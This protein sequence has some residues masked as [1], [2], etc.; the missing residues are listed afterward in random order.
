M[1]PSIPDDSRTETLEF[2]L[3]IADD[4]YFTGHRLGMWLAVSPTLEEDNALTSIAQ[5]ELGHARLWY[6]VV[7]DERSTTTDDLAIGR[8]HDDRRNSILVEREHHD[9][10][11][12]IVRSYLYDRAE[13]LFLESIRDGDVEALADT[14]SV[15]LNEEPFHREHAAKW[16]EVLHATD[17]GTERLERA[18]ETNLEAASDL[19]AFEESQQDAL[20]D[21]G[22]LARS[23][24]ELAETWETEVTKTL[25]E[26]PIDV[27][28]QAVA[29]AVSNSPSTNGRRGEH[30]DEFPAVLEEMEPATID[31]I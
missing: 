17:E 6:D 28:S 2:L 4:E 20:V 15:A 19:F 7:A 22:V 30:T 3:A 18:F 24:D 13:L 14:A 25:S 9:F 1:T 11:D 26:L 16:L 21:A 12:A 8:G 23:P 29:D 31:Q 10:A 27:D 5:D